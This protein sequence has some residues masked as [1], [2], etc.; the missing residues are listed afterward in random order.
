M[1]G[2]LDSPPCV[3]PCVA[4]AGNCY[5]DFV[6]VHVALLNKGAVGRDAGAQYLAGYHGACVEGVAG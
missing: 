3:P 1:E 6:G 2:D 4:E 5:S